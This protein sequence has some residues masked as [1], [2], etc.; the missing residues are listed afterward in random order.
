VLI[1]GA[2]AVVKALTTVKP[3]VVAAA[4]DSQ[5]PGEGEQSVMVYAPT[6]G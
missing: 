3:A 4:D 6:L 2:A 5:H 1:S